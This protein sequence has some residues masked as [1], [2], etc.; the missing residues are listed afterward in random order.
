MRPLCVFTAILLFGTASAQAFDD[1]AEDQCVARQIA[2]LRKNFDEEQRLKN[3]DEQLA[4]SSKLSAKYAKLVER[5]ADDRDPFPALQWLA[6]SPEYAQLAHELLL[7]HHLD[8]PK[9]AKW[10][11]SPGAEVLDQKFDELLAEAPK[12]PA[13]DS[14]RIAWLKTHAAALRSIDPADADF[15]DLEPIGRAIGEARIVML[16]EQ[17]H[18][19]GPTFLAK[20]RLVRFLHEKCGFDVLAFESGLYDC[21]KAWRLLSE[22][23]LPANRAVA[24]G[25]FAIWTQSEQVRPLI[26][27][28]GQQAKTPRPLELAGFDCQFTA[29]ASQTF[30]V[31]ELTAFV[32]KLPEKARPKEEW[33]AIVDACRALTKAPA[34]VDARQKAAFVACRQAL[35]SIAAP[36]NIP[37]AEFEFWKQ[38]IESAA[39]YADAQQFLVTTNFDDRLEYTNVRDPQMARNLVWLARTA[40]PNRKII[41]WAASMHIMR[42]P[43]SVKMIIKAEGRPLEPRQAV[44]HHDKTRTMGNE[45]WQELKDEMYTVAFTA[46]EGEFKLPWW[47]MPQ[48]LDPVVSGSF[49]DLFSRAGFTNAFL[50]FRHVGDDGRWLSEPLISRP[51]GH[52]DSESDWT[53][54]FD[55]IFFTRTMSGS[56]LVKHPSKLV[57]NRPDDRAAKK[58]QERFQG[59]WV[60]EANEANGNKL[61][62]ERLKIYHRTVK[63][64]SYTITIANETGTTRIKG[65]FALKP[66]VSPAEIDAE[67][68]NGEIV[69][70]IYKLE[71]DILTLCISPP[72]VP[73]PTEFA[74]GL[75]TRSTITVWKRAQPSEASNR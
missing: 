22:D 58:E 45:A 35:G 52:A 40:Y 61:P 31:D 54:V 13:V 74:A 8:N 53:K 25:V 60:M 3:R 30:L 75:G 57:A 19:D 29:E 68:E 73:R 62:V 42:N 43:A 63:D 21:H 41:V 15:S 37:L 48:K 72:G 27:Y 39:A 10:F 46:A 66:Q 34:K 9:L 11:G 7:S 56:Y 24:N 44:G 69:L 20:T 64:D 71:G 18:G 67:P 38:F 28:L 6:D 16:G 5:H 59:D 55:A 23:K 36:E 4:L 14:D 12:S 50:D 26:E 70:G 17:A 51:L 33:E 1:K 47:D 2:A 32:E 65:R 49:E